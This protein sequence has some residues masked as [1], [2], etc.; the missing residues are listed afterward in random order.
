MNEEIKI[1]YDMIH[2][3]ETMETNRRFL[4]YAKGAPSD[5]FTTDEQYDRA[6]FVFFTDS[7]VDFCEAESSADNLRRT[8]EYVN[9][10]PVI[11]DAVIH[12]GDVITPF[13][14]IPK[15]DAI[16]RI[17]P[18]LDLAL[19]SRSPLLFAKGNH[20]LNDWGNTPSEVISD[21]DWSRIYL[22]QAEEKFGIVRQTKASGE[23]STWHYLD[24]PAHKI[25]IVAVDV[26]DTDKSSVNPKGNVKYYGGNS[27]YV[28]DE[29]M[30]W[31]AS[32]A[33]N[34]D[35]KAEADWGVIFAMHM[36]Q[37][38]S[39]H[40]NAIEKLLRMCAAFNTQGIFEE[41]YN[42]PENSF[43]DL[44]VKADFT[45]YAQTEKKPHMICWLLGHNHHDLHEI[46]HGIHLIWTLNNSAST[47]C[48]DSSVVRIPG[49]STQNAFDI[50]NVDTR[51]RKI[52]IF[53]FG[54][55]INCFGIGGDRFLPDGLSY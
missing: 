26:Q 13:G 29:Q 48:G 5:Q 23:K 43:F 47:V 27:W 30:N 15:E 4:P 28:S 54:A 39:V 25:R 19:E 53:R 1:S 55:G 7:H 17:R 2:A 46:R 8:M 11:F 12:T 38:S 40:E 51:H 16:S 50:V 24:I 41:K 44:D 3:M 35:D 34:F 49:T 36:L 32:E 18:F 33:L 9:S 52:R 6:N 10:A 42:H 20:D 37:D 22:N 31:I 45:R 21:S 14:R